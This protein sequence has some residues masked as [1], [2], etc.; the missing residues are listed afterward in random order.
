[1]EGVP[2]LKSVSV[3]NSDEYYSH[4]GVSLVARGAGAQ[5]GDMLMMYANCQSDRDG[6]R[7]SFI[8]LLR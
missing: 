4:E 5:G 1:M 7:D 2:V 6:I 3:T 8:C